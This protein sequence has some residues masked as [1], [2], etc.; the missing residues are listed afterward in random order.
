MEPKKPKKNNSDKNLPKIVYKEEKKEPK[1]EVKCLIETHLK[2]ATERIKKGL[3]G[4]DALYPSSKKSKI[5]I[6]SKCGRCIIG[7]IYRIVNDTEQKIYCTKCSSENNL[8][9]FIIK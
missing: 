8:P 7:N 1:E 3:S 4:R 6:C 2:A 9:M 5:K